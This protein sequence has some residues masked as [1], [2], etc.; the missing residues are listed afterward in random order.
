VV[1]SNSG[2]PTN[3]AWLYK[4]RANPIVTVET[5]SETFRARATAT[6]GAERRRLWDHHVAE[7]P[8][9]ADYERMAER[10][11]PVVVLERRPAE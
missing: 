9:F 7:I 6:T 5:G 8:A 4:V 11:I 2:A 3:S 10:E 1:G